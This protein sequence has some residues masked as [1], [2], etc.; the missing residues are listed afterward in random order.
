MQKVN[1]VMEE[2]GHIEF[3]APNKYYQNL[4]KKRSDATLISERI[5]I[6]KSFYEKVENTWQPEEYRLI[7]VK[8]SYESA[9]APAFVNVKNAVPKVISF[10]VE[11]VGGEKLNNVDTELFRY[12]LESTWSSYSGKVWV[13]DGLPLK[14][15]MWTPE[16]SLNKIFMTTQY[17]YPK[18]LSINDPLAARPSR[19]RSKQ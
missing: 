7:D 14:A 9:L 1:D 11:F 16:G 4:A 19:K 17:S 18:D 13:A 10:S 6:G 2:D 8:G 15:E 3:V 12:E 5:Q